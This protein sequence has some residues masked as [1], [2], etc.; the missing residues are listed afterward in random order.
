VKG[1]SPRPVATERLE[2]GWR[3]LIGLPELGVDELRAKIDTGARTSALHAVDLAVIDRGRDSFVTFHLPHPGAA[4]SD[5]C[6][7]RIVDRRLIKNSGGLP[8]ERYIIQ[9]LLTLGRRHWHI[10]VSLADRENMEFDLIIGRTAIRGR[11][12][13]VNPG[14]SYLAGPPGALS[15]PADDALGT[16]NRRKRG[17][18][19]GSLEGTSQ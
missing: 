7:S 8:E 3:E 12:L 11:R 9:T 18:A 16:R 19:A 15:P 13:L 6:V 2:I 14:K 10:E 17:P 5:R 1:S 4:R